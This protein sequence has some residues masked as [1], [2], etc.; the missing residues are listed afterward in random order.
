MTKN[1]IYENLEAAK[2]V[3]KE[4]SK[5]ILELQNKLGI[6]DSG[7][8]ESIISTIYRDAS[9][10]EKIFS[11]SQRRALHFKTSVVDEVEE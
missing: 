11:T 1:I 5:A 4:C 10:A 2:L 9:G 6:W 7:E 3:C 8:D